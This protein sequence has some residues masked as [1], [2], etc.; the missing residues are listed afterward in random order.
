MI[1]IHPIQLEFPFCLLA[2]SQ[3]YPHLPLLAIFFV[4]QAPGGPTAIVELL[5]VHL[6]PGCAAVEGAIGAEE[7]GRVSDVGVGG[8]HAEA[9]RRV[10]PDVDVTL[11]GALLDPASAQVGGVGRFLEDDLPGVAA[12]GCFGNAVEQVLVAL[13]KLKAS[14]AGIGDLRS[15]SRRSSPVLSAMPTTASSLCERR[16]SALSLF[17]RWNWLR[18]SWESVTARAETW[19]NSRDFALLQQGGQGLD[20]SGAEAPKDHPRSVLYW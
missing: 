8:R 17:R 15:S 16:R 13:G 20:G 4:S 7:V 11:P 19:T 12:I 18:K 10:E 3:S 6:L 5:R 9:F 1:G 2:A 14:E